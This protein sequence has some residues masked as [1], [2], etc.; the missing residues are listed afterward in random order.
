MPLTDSA[1]ETKQ[2]DQDKFGGNLGYGETLWIFKPQ[3]LSRLSRIKRIHGKFGQ[4]HPTR[5]GSRS[6]G[7][8]T[9]KPAQ[10]AEH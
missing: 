3:V 7:F 1:V 5:N 10:Y 2:F 4:V 8:I 9:G 6:I